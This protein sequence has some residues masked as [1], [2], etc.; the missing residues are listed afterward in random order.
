MLTIP[1]EFLLLTVNDEGDGFVDIPA[2]AL[3][4][5]FVGAAIMELAL[6]NRIDADLE[7]IWVFDRSRVNELCVDVVLA[8]TTAPGFQFAAER[9]IEQLI[10]LGK[11][12]RSLALERLCERR[13][14]RVIDGRQFWF[15]KTRRY[16]VNDGQEV[17]EAKLRLLDVLLHDQIPDPRDICLLSLAESSGIIRQ[18]VPTDACD[19]LGPR[20][21]TLARMD[22]IGQNVARYIQIFREALPYTYLSP[23]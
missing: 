12:V 13:I 2:E 15:L 3:D 4:A 11:S 9:L 18:I 19:R 20:L 17:R 14:L 10:G 5:G 8:K 7:R 16:P 21:A 22:L 6:R 23:V 1:E